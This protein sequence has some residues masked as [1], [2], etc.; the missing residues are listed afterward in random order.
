MILPHS[1][2]EDSTP[3]RRRRQVKPGGNIAYI[4]TFIFNNPGCTSTHARKALCEYN[5]IEWTNGTDM[6]GQYT[7][8]FCT[9]WI[10]G[11]SWPRNPCGRYWYR[12]KRP[13]GKTG[14]LVTVEGLS[15]VTC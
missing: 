1:E 2:I 15:K 4:A 6:R 12:V 13:D 10:G 9:G 7:S 3:R 8:Y 5:G 14:H 11:R